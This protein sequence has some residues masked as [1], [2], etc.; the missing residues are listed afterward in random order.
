MNL[1]FTQSEQA[2]FEAFEQKH[3]KC[4]HKGKKKYRGGLALNIHL[5]T[6][7]IAI[8]VIVKCCHCGTKENIS[9]YDSW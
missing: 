9:D 4:M 8:A 3:S 7:G 5:R 6:T 2:A 1:K